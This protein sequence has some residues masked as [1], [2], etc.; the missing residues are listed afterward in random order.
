MSLF[1]GRNWQ[2]GAISVDSGSLG[3]RFPAAKH[4]ARIFALV[5]KGELVPAR[6][7]CCD[8]YALRQF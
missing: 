8:A 5:K 2:S 4:N 1:E 6:A 3:L 7:S